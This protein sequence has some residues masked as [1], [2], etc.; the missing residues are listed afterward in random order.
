MKELRALV[1]SW[2]ALREPG[3]PCVLA[4]V[5]AVNGSAYR[6]PGARMLMTEERWHAGSVSGGCL[7]RELLR[8]AF[9][10][11]AR[12]Q[13]ARLVFDSLSED[14]A[15]FLRTGCGGRVE[16]LL[17]RPQRE[18]PLN[19]LEFLSHCVL[20]RRA[21]VMATVLYTE[22]EVP[23]PLAARLMLEADGNV[24]A[25][26][27]LL[28]ALPL[29]EEDARAT[30]AEN[31]S[32]T[33]TYELAGGR[34]DVFLERVQPL[35]PLVVFG[36]GHD[37]V[38]LVEAARGVGWHVTVV[39]RRPQEMTDR[40]QGRVDAVVGSPP[41]AAATAVELGP[42]TAVVVMTHQYEADRALLAALVASP[43]RYIGVLGPKS[44]TERILDELAREGQ[45]WTDAQRGRVYAPAGL[46]VG[47]EGPEEIA[48]AIV[49][50]VRA[51]TSGRQG[52]FLK[53]RQG[54]IHVDPAAHQG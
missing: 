43:V 12:G 16:L 27:G 38:A 40:L 50:E 24:R 35:Q 37:V 47:A 15:L 7:E 31:F 51:L 3:A 30:E 39:T 1:E 11:T 5:V 26:P 52:G 33:R 13:P 32:R 4:T 21:G 28:E 25:S 46:D 9:W 2:E 53:Y 45:V 54:P 44:R 49:A 8:K 20:R 23:V 48:L 17:E 18:D 42:R 41:E 34:V 19:P 14:D 6:R 10:L 36:G 22:G 29:L